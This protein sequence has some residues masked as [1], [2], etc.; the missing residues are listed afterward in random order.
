MYIE[1]KLHVPTDQHN[2]LKRAIAGKTKQVSITISKASLQQH[3]ATGEH[4]LLLTPTQI[5]KLQNAQSNEAPCTLL[6][7]R[8]QIDANI[9]HHG[10]FLSLLAGLTTKLLPSLIGALAAGAISGT[11]EKAIT[12]KKGSGF[13]LHKNRSWYKLTPH[14]KGRGLYLSP[15]P[16]F[17]GHYGNGLYV[18]RGTDISD[19]SGLILG[20]NSPFK[21][22]PILNLIL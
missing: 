7:R 2:K 6:M 21:H 18:K 11:V 12:S 1:H 19:G 8:K 20:P 15:H 3:N 14:A 17:P 22:I 4:T 10:G 5:L 9:H 16:T 13:F